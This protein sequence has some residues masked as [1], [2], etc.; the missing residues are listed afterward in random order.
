TFQ[1]LRFQ[2]SNSSSLTEPVH[3]CGDIIGLA[4]VASLQEEVNSWTPELMPSY[5]LGR[6]HQMMESTK[7][8]LEWHVVLLQEASTSLASSSPWEYGNSRCLHHSM[9]VLVHREPY[10]HPFIVLQGALRLTFLIGGVK[11]E[12]VVAALG[13][14][15]KLQELLKLQM[16]LLVEEEEVANEVETQVAFLV[17]RDSFF[18]LACFSQVLCEF[19][20]V[21][22]VH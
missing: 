2:L 5:S 1:V 3:K 14:I 13:R 8:V 11:V 16:V 7:Q 12:V 18:L 9:T 15:Q 4:R 10:P 19:L 17:T 6:T 21:I 22:M 20:R